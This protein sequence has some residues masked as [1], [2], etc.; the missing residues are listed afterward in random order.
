MMKLI[1]DYNSDL[2]KYKEV[3]DETGGRL[4]SLTFQYYDCFCGHAEYKIISSTTRHRNHFDVV[5]CTKCGTL[6]LNPYMSDSAIETYY[7]EIYGPIKRKNMT[8]EA[9]FTRQSR[10]ADDL[11]GVVSTQVAKDAQL[12]DYGSGAGGRMSRFKAEGYPNVHL[13][14]Y[15]KKYLDYGVSQGFKAHAEGNRYDMVTLSHVLEHVN[16]PVE[17]L[18]KLARDYL[19]PNGKVYIEVPLFEEHEKLIGDFHLAHKFYFT[20]ASLTILAELA[21]FKKLHDDDDA[22]VVTPSAATIEVSAGEYAHALAISNRSLRAALRKS[23]S[24]KRKLALK[25][26]IKG[27]L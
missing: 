16:Q 1:Y 4:K 18:Q 9:L 10:S 14:D 7:K 11:F 23:G 2:H 27:S 20:R 13:F 15:D 25:H 6:R 17:F 21:G 24:I 19:K 8:A 3:H 5:Q 26:I 12:L 22:I